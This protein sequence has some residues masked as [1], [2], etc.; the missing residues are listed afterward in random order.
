MKFLIT[1]AGGLLGSHLVPLLRE[2]GKLF[3]PDRAT[4]DLSRPLDVA[5]LPA[6]IDV[7]VHLAQSRRF[8]DFPDG[9]GDMFQ[10][11]TAS[12]VAL[13]D[14]ARRAGASHFVYAS[15]G[16]VYA[17]SDAPIG[18]E[19]TLAEPMG[20][21]PASKRAAELLLAPFEA[22]F[23]VAVLRYFF[24][25]GPGQSRDMLVPRLIDSVGQGRQIAL[26]GEDGL[27]INPVHV[28]DAAQAT[29]AATRLDRSATINVAGPQQLSLRQIGAAIGAALGREPQF[30]VA[31]QSKANALIAD[32]ARMAVLLG[33]PTRAF[34]DEVA[35]LC[36]R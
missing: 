12:T 11:N 13:A 6:T 19:A 10:V 1:G 21:Y 16:G 2:S 23:S 25:Y 7:V 27:R 22:H 3:T 33:A 36:T 26:D 30:A 17:P 34:T 15:T 32:T 18:E 28:S 29:F 14:Y 31:D 8:R 24:I 5:A 4:L 35:E 20:F 9:A